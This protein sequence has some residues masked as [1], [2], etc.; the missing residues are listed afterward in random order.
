MAR[1]M[2]TGILDE[3]LEENCQD[4]RYALCNYKDQFPS[5]PSAFVWANE[6]IFSKTGSWNHSKDEYNEIIY[7]IF[8]DPYYLSL[9]SYKGLVS[10]AKQLFTF[11]LIIRRIENTSRD[12]RT[13]ELIE[14]NFKHEKKKFNSSLQHKGVDISNIN[15]SYYLF[16]G[17]S[18][19]IVVVFLL[20]KK[21]DYKSN[22]W[23]LTFTILLGVI[24]NAVINGTFSNVVPRYQ[25]RINWMIV[26]VALIIF[27]KY[28]ILVLKYIKTKVNSVEGKL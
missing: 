17:L 16:F 27:Q 2:E 8:S 21:P 6:S 9:F 25:A 13:H 1:I 5:Y 15:L 26:M 19:I 23:F 10:S 3:F 11:N 7:R 12:K 22:L 24:F 28:F 4:N 20:G 18:L 14:K